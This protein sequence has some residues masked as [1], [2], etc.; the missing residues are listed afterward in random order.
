VI[1]GRSPRRLIGVEPWRVRIDAALVGSSPNQSSLI[2]PTTARK[3]TNHMA[4]WREAVEF[5]SQSFEIERTYGVPSLIRSAI[6]GM[7]ARVKIPKI[8]DAARKT[9]S[10]FVAKV[11]GLSVSAPATQPSAATVVTSRA[12]TDSGGVPSLFW[13]RPWQQ[14]LIP[15]AL[16]PDLCPFSG[17]D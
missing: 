4:T 2:A 11:K 1:A 5:V 6:I 17:S 12:G 9:T 8:T 7:T 16:N 13:S 15:T 14:N 10:N 3:Q